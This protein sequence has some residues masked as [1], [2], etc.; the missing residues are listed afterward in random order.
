MEELLKKFKAGEVSLQEVKKHLKGFE[1]LNHSKI[2]I[3]REKR[4]GFPEIVYGESKTAEQIID[5][6][7][8]LEK[9]TDA[10]LITRI[11]HAKAEEVAQFSPDLKY[12]PTA[13][14]MYS[15]PEFHGE[16]SFIAVLSAGTSDSK[17]SEEAAISAQVLGCRVERFYD[18]GVA[19]I[20]R[21]FHQIDRIRQAKVI[22]VVAGM[23]GALA[24]VVGGLVSVP[25]IAVPTSVGYGSN[26]GGLS[27]LL[28]MLNSC[29][30]GI[31]VVNIDNG[32]GAAYN[33]CQIMQLIPNKNK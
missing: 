20:H 23:E 27:A 12:H 26:F 28:T 4:T 10:I 16:D 17:V 15:E 5:I 9:N 32:F 6:L 8:S 7:E 18:I 31:S 2:D 21:L 22:I 29:A 19:G 11:N 3:Q 25:I 24:S 1:E 30:S 33:A 13:Q 14:L